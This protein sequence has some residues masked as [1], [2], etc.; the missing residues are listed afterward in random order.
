MAFFLVIVKAIVEI[1]GMALI[2]QFLVGLFSWG[3][4]Q[5]N[6]L[7]QLFQIVTRPFTRLT[8][9]ITPKLV[10]DQHIPLATFFLLAIV[11]VVVLLELA[12]SCRS[13]PQQSAC[14]EVRQ[15]R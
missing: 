15:E 5:Q 14:S 11:W 12:S 13:D 6:I 1:A 3:R 10:V 9:L 4:R 7:Y 8:R 2:A